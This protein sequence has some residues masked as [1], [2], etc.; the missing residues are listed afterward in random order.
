MRVC[1]SAVTA[2]QTRDKMNLCSL[3]SVCLG[4]RLLITQ[5]RFVEPGSTGAALL[6][7]AGYYNKE[8]FG[9]A[10]RDE[11]AGEIPVEL[12]EVPLPNDWLK[13]APSP[14]PA[15][16]LPPANMQTEHVVLLLWRDEHYDRDDDDEFNHMMAWCVCLL[17][18]DHVGSFIICCSVLQ[19]LNRLPSLCPNAGT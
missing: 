3:M 1:V 17:T 4:E 6:K 19:L 13:G 12:D 18:L 10:P 15:A 16:P 2:H 5:E 9:F 14:P 8:A 11:K 7:S